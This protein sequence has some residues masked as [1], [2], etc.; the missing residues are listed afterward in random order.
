[1][2]MDTMEM[3]EGK[4]AKA[5]PPE[6]PKRMIPVRLDRNTIIMVPEGAD[7]DAHV[8]KYKERGYNPPG[9]FPD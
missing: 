1:M 4:R 9:S 5:V 2:S 8:R 3:E 7:I 6:P